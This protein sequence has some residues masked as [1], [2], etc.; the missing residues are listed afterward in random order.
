MH[1]LGVHQLQDTQQEVEVLRSYSQLQQ[2]VGVDSQRGAGHYRH[3]NY[4]QVEDSLQ[5]PEEGI[6]V[7]YMDSL[8]CPVGNN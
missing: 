4:L 2:E 3:Y 6:A 8:R 1:T 5:L 7:D